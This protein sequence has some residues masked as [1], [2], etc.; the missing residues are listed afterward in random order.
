MG[1]PFQDPDVVGS[2]C[3]KCGGY[4]MYPCTVCE[5]SRRS[6]NSCHR[7]GYV[8]LRC[9]MCDK[10]SEN[11]GTLLFRPLEYERPARIRKKAVA[12]EAWYGPHDDV[13]GFFPVTPGG[14]KAGKIRKFVAKEGEKI[15]VKFKIVETQGHQFSD[16]S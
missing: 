7:N 15:G 6:S 4:G 8:T 10:A 13:V 3:D 14:V 9:T 2:V 11:S 12:K 16:V 5:G 1:R